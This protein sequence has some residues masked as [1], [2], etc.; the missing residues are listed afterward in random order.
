MPSSIPAAW[1]EGDELVTG[2]VIL[3]R[4]AVKRFVCKDLSTPQ[5]RIEQSLLDFGSGFLHTCSGDRHMLGSVLLG[6]SLMQLSF[7][8]GAC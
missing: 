2:N 4:A 7:A 1:L 8:P 3:Y 5:K 6:L